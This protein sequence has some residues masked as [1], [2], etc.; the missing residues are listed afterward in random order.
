MRTIYRNIG[1]S[2]GIAILSQTAAAAMDEARP[3][4]AVSGF[5][6]L[7]Q[8]DE[9]A[10]P[11]AAESKPAADPSSPAAATPG[12]VT[13]TA[14]KSGP[15]VFPGCALRYLAAEVSGKLKGRKWKEFRQE[16]CGSSEVTAVFP[17]AIAPK[18]TGEKPDKARTLTCADQFS[19]NK[20]TNGNGG[21]KWVEKSG[22]YYSE[23]IV[24]LKG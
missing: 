11:A 22:G 1:A 2:I 5:Q 10:K 6:Q 19:A 12:T 15:S 16:E 3:V 7:A 20:S 23:C 17:T 9:A 18:Y 8:A 24:R 4:K 13:A 14:T 21:L